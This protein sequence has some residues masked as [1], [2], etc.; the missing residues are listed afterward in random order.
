MTATGDLQR[1]FVGI[2]VGD[3]A[4]P[5][6][7]LARALDDVGRMASWFSAQSGKPHQPAAPALAANPAWHEILSQL[8]G[9]LKERSG[10]DVVVI[11]VACHG[12]LE[13][14]EGYLF[15]RDTPRENLAGVAV[16][17]S[18][19]GRIVGSSGAQ[20]VLLIVDACVAGSIAASIADA[21]Q[22]AVLE[23]RKQDPRR[24][25]AQVVLSST[26][27]LEPAL[28]GEFVDA[29]L[30]V[31]S[32][33]RWTGTVRHWIAM[34]QLIEGLNAE[35]DALG[36]GQIA[37]IRVW[38]NSEV[39]L[40][41]NPNL[42]QDEIFL[43]AEF[44][45]HF[46]PA[47]RGVAGTESGQF[48]TGRTEE[49]RRITGW[50]NAGDGPPMLLI[51][52]SAGTGKSALLG[53]I[54]VLSTPD[55]WPAGADFESLPEGTVPQAGA[56]DRVIW[57][58]G[59]TR[60]QLIG[61]FAGVFGG[62]ATTM[63]ALL[64]LAKAQG[65]G[66]VVAVDA[67]DEATSTEAASIATDLLVPL[68]SQSPVRLLLATRRQSPLGDDL[69][70]ALQ[71]DGL[72][73][74]DLDEAIAQAQ[75]MKAYVQ[76]RLKALVPTRGMT[77]DDRDAAQTRLAGAISNAAGKSFLV[78]SIA[79]RSITSLDNLP[80]D[81]S[82]PV[83]VGGALSAY[84][85]RFD[86]AERIRE[87]LRPLAWSRGAGQP[88]GVVW[89]R[90]ASALSKDGRVV[91]DADIAD[92]LRSASDL[93]VESVDQSEPVYRVHEALAE[94]LRDTTPDADTAPARIAKALLSLAD[95]RPWAAVPRYARMNL[96]ELLRQA[97]MADDLAR[98]MLDPAWE[99]QLRNENAAA[100]DLTH[101]V[102]AA[103]ALFAA[104]ARLSDLAPLCH[105]YS[106]TT[107][108]TLPALIEVL[109]LSG[110]Q[111]RAE[112]FAANLTDVVDRML[113]FRGLAAIYA[114]DGDLA[115]AWRCAAEVQRTLPAM[116]K[117]HRPMALAWAVE[118]YAA[119]HDTE[120]ALTCAA[121]SLEAVGQNDDWDRMNGLFW[122][123]RAAHLAGD[124]DLTARLAG[125][126]S[127]LDGPMFR[128]QALQ[129]ASLSG[130]TD[131]LRGLLE[132]R[133]AV[134]SGQ[135]SSI[136]YG[137][138]GLA[139][140]DAGLLADF[141][142]LVSHAGEAPPNEEDDSLKRWAW[143]HA[144]AG[145]FQTAIGI[146]RAIREPIEKSKAI[147]RIAP[148]V[149]QIADR[150]VRKPIEDSLAA[151]ASSL[152]IGS[153]P[154]SRARLIRALWS[155]GAQQQALAA[156]EQEIASGAHASPFVDLRAE[157]LR[158]TTTKQT[159]RGKM[160]RRA[161]TSSRAPVQDQFKCYEVETAALDNDLVLARRLADEIK[162]PQFKAEAL[163]AI[164]G[165]EVDSDKALN[166]WCE[167]LILA[168]RAGRGSVE[169][170][171]P[172]GAALLRAA[173]RPA[174]A[175]ALAQRI[176]TIDAK[177]QLEKFIDE[178]SAIR[179]N[180]PPGEDRT[181]TMTRLLYV[182]I[183]LA[184]NGESRELDVHDAW[185]R[186][187]DGSRMFAI[188]MMQGDPDLLSPEIMYDAI[189]NSRSAF[190]QFNALKAVAGLPETRLI[191][192]RVLQA[193]VEEMSGQP[194]QDGT[195][196]WLEGSDRR[197]LAT[198]ILERAAHSAP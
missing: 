59:K 35:L 120:A 50:I 18:Q 190:E 24:K 20:N 101:D 47:A 39:A 53:R 63:E 86:S 37:D 3:Y 124:A 151:E 68:A 123:A 23:R 194:R 46:D 56:I 130:S 109:A 197:R 193:V 44:A 4:D 72:E 78:A 129:A 49:L 42:P 142:R 94:H 117:D 5:T 77:E 84:L 160:A 154:R 80:Q 145:N 132:E 103:A 30:N 66:V 138:L 54:A 41:P 71:M 57:C 171:L 161:M 81:D 158:D 61:E 26:Y 91:S 195:R 153:E 177:W 191:D 134:E 82:L 128:N 27:G 31:V 43:G 112:A 104:Q 168:R 186:G 13:A 7:N 40:V 152:M 67:L 143:A 121:L 135:H 92:A 144:L 114:A 159:D 32:N 167:A 76:T 182:P 157:D 69:I 75:D 64:I 2:G 106:R 183:G 110:Q 174:E 11:Y 87:V 74:L 85:D 21:T 93:I 187:E 97:G 96:P 148:L 62:N 55:M 176:A 165:A 136:R 107:A 25:F 173:G 196:A 65:K 139:L 172:V 122:A 175:D 180:M 38:S 189:R 162:V 29:F 133:L 73:V 10:S 79:A 105:Q 116:P 113:A 98:I 70:A 150:D 99:R 119:A 137:N 1:W 169:T 115:S 58:H 188:G 33:E 16:P 156:L 131:V 90:L 146:V 126:V 164:A 102:E 12:E 83:E 15:G 127:A 51:T 52:G 8:S 36:G 60:G 166:S 111:L 149:A 45:M 170:V 125:L 34:D 88:W 95:G 185:A 100:R 9:F 179:V 192:P 181:R 141:A 184:R 19:L 198:L 163:L 89:G 140:A 108:Q 22:T 28:D 155:L 147:T 17:A 6:L 178:Y 118:A 48:F 14:G